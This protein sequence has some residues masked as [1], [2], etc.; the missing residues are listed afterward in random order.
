VSSIQYTSLVPHARPLHTISH[1]ENAPTVTNP[2]HSYAPRLSLKPRSIKPL[3]PH[4]AKRQRITLSESEKRPQENV[5]I[6]LEHDSSADG[7]ANQNANL[8]STRHSAA[9]GEGYTRTDLRPCHICHQKPKVRSDLDSYGDCEG[10]GERTC[11]I[12]MRECLGPITPV[13][14]E[15]I[16]T[17]SGMSFTTVNDELSLADGAEDRGVDGGPAHGQDDKDGDGWL[18]KEGEVWG[19]RDMVCS[20]CCVERGVDGEVRCLGCLRAEEG[21]DGDVIGS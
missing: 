4:D 18:G 21:E 11:Y 13:A 20:Q 9:R 1:H 19:H 8:A 16:E 6:A 17:E 10:C 15:S 5:D 12:C 14:W 3:C 7:S 2:H